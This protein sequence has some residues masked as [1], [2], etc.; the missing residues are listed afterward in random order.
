MPDNLRLRA[1]RRRHPCR[2]HQAAVG[3]IVDTVSFASTEL[4]AAAGSLT[5]TAEV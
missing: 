3:N 4:E 5:K 2:P 1:E